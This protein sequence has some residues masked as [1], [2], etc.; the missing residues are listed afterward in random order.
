MAGILDMYDPEVRAAMQGFGPS[1]ED[2]QRAM[3]MGLLHAGL[4]MLASN[5]GYGSGQALSNAIGQG[6]IH[7]LNAYSQQL[8]DAERDQMRQLQAAQLAQG[9]VQQQRKQQGLNTM[10]AQH[11]DMAELFKLNPDLALKRLYPEDQYKSVGNTLLKVGPQGVTPQYTEPQKAPDGFRYDEAGGLQVMPGWLDAKRQIAAAGRPHTEIKLPPL[12]NEEQKAL[13]K[14]LAEQYSAI[15]KGGLMAAG[16]MNNLTRMKSLLNGVET[17]KLTPAMTEVSA[18]L[19]SLGIKIDPRLPQKQAV[20]A[21]SNELALRAKNQGG[22]NLMP[23]A[24]SDPDRRFL[25]EMVPS[26]ANTP[27][28]NAIILE[29]LTRKAQRDQ[30]VAKMARDY[31][32][33]NRTLDGFAEQLAGWSAQNPLF[34]DL[35]QRAPAPAAPAAG[36][37]KIIGVR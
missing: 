17:G 4:G 11:P 3:S 23:G 9:M 25:T 6:G 35:Q 29:T 37:F 21:L 26:L 32:K 18:T 14:D 12:E 30:E 19:D 5:R 24:M 33:K 13:G 2:K 27:G 36:G 20:A 22:E 34:S 8:N 1:A 15:Q 10:A 7:G 16:T 28:G 31:R